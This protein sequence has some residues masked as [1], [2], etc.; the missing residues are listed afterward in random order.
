MLHSQTLTTLAILL[1]ILL[2]LVVLWTTAA[3]PR[4]AV[5]CCAGAAAL[6]WPV[7]GWS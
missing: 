4:H 3:R 2:P 6:C 7:S 5:L 1:Q